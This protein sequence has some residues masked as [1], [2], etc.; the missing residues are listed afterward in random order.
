MIEAVACFGA[1]SQALAMN[2]NLLQLLE[3][4]TL[5]GERIPGICTKSPSK[6][7][8]PASRAPALEAFSLPFTIVSFQL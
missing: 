4:G 5:D 7:V 6:V 1:S 8:E 3:Y 2:A